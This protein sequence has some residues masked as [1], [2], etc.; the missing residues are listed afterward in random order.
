M[1]DS[2]YTTQY[3]L[4]RCF[5]ATTNTLYANNSGNSNPNPNNVTKYR[6]QYIW[7]LIFDEDNDRLKT[8]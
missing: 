3:I 2:K 6:E 4:N 1:N 5:N 8:T 7:N